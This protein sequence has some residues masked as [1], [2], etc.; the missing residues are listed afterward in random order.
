MDF[1][2][3]PK[4][5]VVARL[6]VYLTERHAQRIRA[7]WPTDGVCDWWSRSPLCHQQTCSVSACKVGVG[8][9][10]RPLAGI[11]RCAC[12]SVQHLSH[13]KAL[14]A[15]FSDPT[16]TWT[17]PTRTRPQWPLGGQICPL[18]SMAHNHSNPNPYQALNDI[19]ARKRRVTMIVRR[20]KHQWEPAQSRRP[21]PRPSPG[22]TPGRLG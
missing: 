4:R 5:R 19:L 2:D 8:E 14:Y 13:S 21:A 3:S 17:L 6:A 12:P 22:G 1:H 10:H 11:A 7:F 20:L 16:G 9:P 15:P 18:F